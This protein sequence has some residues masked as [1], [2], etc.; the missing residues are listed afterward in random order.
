MADKQGVEIE[1]IYAEMSIVREVDE[2][3]LYRAF[4][5]YHP[6]RYPG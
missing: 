3:M 1:T 6:Q 4:P 5:Q 2:D